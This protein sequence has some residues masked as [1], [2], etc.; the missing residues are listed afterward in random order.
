MGGEPRW[1]TAEER[2][3]GEETYEVTYRAGRGQGAKKAAEEGHPQKGP[4]TP[5][6]GGRRVAEAMANCRSKLHMDWERQQHKVT[7]NV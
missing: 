5:G 3:A 4:G 2:H 6:G 1:S 7:V